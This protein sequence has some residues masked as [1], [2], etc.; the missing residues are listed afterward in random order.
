MCQVACLWLGCCKG[1]YSPS[2]CHTTTCDIGV[3]EK[4]YL[5]F[6][7]NWLSMWMGTEYVNFISIQRTCFE[8]EINK[9]TNLKFLTWIGVYVRQSQGRQCTIAICGGANILEIR[10][11]INIPDLCMQNDK[12]RS[13]SYE[14]K[15][16]QNHFDRQCNTK[17][18]SRDFFK[19]VC[20]F[21]S[22]KPSSS[23]GKIILCDYGNIISDP[24]HPHMSLISLICIT[25]LSRHILDVLDSFT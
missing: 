20:P 25:C 19:T 14:K 7:H 21:L 17:F 24:S 5:F 16:I 22:D 15:I 4:H 9:L 10:R 3:I 8:G 11:T 18:N 23:N 13:P 6:G 1:I 2:Y 12:K